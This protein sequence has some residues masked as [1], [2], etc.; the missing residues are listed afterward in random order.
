MVSS[1]ICSVFWLLLL[2]QNVFAARNNGPRGVAVVSQDNLRRLKEKEEKKK[3]KGP[4]NRECKV[5]QKKSKESGE[6]EEVNF[7]CK[8][9]K[10][11]GKKGQL[12]DGI[13]FNV[14]QDESLSVGVDYAQT[15]A[16]TVTTASTNTSQETTSQETTSQETT[17]QTRYE[18]VFDSIIE[19]K[20]NKTSTTSMDN[21]F[22]SDNTTSSSNS[23]TSENTTNSGGGIIDDNNTVVTI[24]EN[25]TDVTI[26]ENST[27]VTIDEN[28]TDVTNNANR[29]LST[30]ATSEA[31]DW[32]SDN[33]VQRYSLDGVNMFS[34]PDESNDTI[35][36]TVTDA[37]NT[38]VFGFTINPGG[39]DLALDANNSGGRDLAVD[40]N[41]AIDANTMK[42][43]F[44]L[45][46]FPW[47]QSDTYVA[48]LC[49][50]VSTQRIA[51]ETLPEP[52][53]PADDAG[54]NAT[55]DEEVPPGDTPPLNVTERDLESDPLLDGP[56][57]KKSLE[58]T[59]VYVSFDDSIG[60]SDGVTASG[61]YS[62]AREAREMGSN[63]ILQVVATSTEGSDWVAY[64][65]VGP[66]AHSATDIYWD[67]EAGI[68]YSEASSDAAPTSA[69]K[70]AP[71]SASL[72]AL[73]YHC[74]AAAAL[75]SIGTFFLL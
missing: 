66:A 74:F 15:T 11:I 75:F 48:L 72:M 49:R 64:S 63:T 28:S 71:T 69:P 19:Y 67:P 5:S 40:A 9:K 41:T 38:V 13:E 53:A 31:F 65:F 2:S 24:D 30:D 12:K 18:I 6:V 23:T 37:N 17:T 43:D 20:K 39:K 21:T 51:I 8:A 32:Q 61:A 45:I 35:S 47:M 10:G 62:W 16:S 60:S 46:G 50:I 22:S 14:K 58:A 42:I 4:E 3:V 34:E 55:E 44:E 52:A 68:S 36:F 54:R 25:S 1:T 59:D 33:I 73:R 7:S 29:A 56:I 27:D 70:F 57:G 26:D